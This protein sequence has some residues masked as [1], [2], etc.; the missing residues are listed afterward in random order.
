MIRLIRGLHSAAG[1]PVFDTNTAGK[2]PYFWMDS[3]RYSCF[4]VL[5]LED[6]LVEIFPCDR[7]MLPIG[8]L[9]LAHVLPK[10][11]HFLAVRNVF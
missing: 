9:S 3:V 2:E 7:R 1:L 11:T 5:L 6:V 8:F 4:C 10:V